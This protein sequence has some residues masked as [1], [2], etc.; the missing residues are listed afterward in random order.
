MLRRQLLVEVAEVAVHDVAADGAERLRDQ[1]VQPPVDVGDVRIAADGVAGELGAG[2]AGRRSR[3]GLAGG[4]RLSG[5]RR[6]ALAC[7]RARLLRRPLLRR[8]RLRRLARG[9]RLLDLGGQL[10]LVLAQL[11]EGDLADRQRHLLGAAVGEQRQQVVERDLLEQR[12]VV[13]GLLGVAAQHEDAVV[14]EDVGVGAARELLRHVLLEEA[15]PRRGVRDELHRAAEVAHLFVEQGGDR[16]LHQ[17]ERARVRLVRVDDH[18]RVGAALVHGRVHGGLDRR[19]PRAED[20]P[21]VEAQHADVAG[22]HLAV[23]V[24]RR[25]DREGVLAGHAHGDVALRGLEVAALEQRP[26]DV[27]DELP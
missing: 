19:L 9:A 12:H 27:D 6:R 22:L 21:P 15:R 3:A 23:V 16:P 26:A 4:R 10:L 13:H 20:L 1:A 25:R 24:A 7:G 17:R 18:A 8:A 5:R 2:G 11:L 14:L